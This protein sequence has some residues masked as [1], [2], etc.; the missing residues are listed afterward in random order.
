[1]F[2]IRN[3]MSDMTHVWSSFYLRI[4]LGH[5]C[6]FPSCVMPSS[7]RML[8]RALLLRHDHAEQ[9]CSLPDAVPELALSFLLAL[10]WLR[11]ATRM[12]STREW[13]TP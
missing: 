11:N 12:L 9:S 3:N 8:F 5:V 4:R 10:S 2:V 7:A 6:A 13:T 1:M